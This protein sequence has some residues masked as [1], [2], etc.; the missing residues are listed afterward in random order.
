MTAAGGETFQV[1]IKVRHFNPL[2]GLATSVGVV[3][4]GE[5]DFLYFM[6]QKALVKVSALLLVFRM[7]KKLSEFLSWSCVGSKAPPN[8]DP[9]E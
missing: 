9:V 3:D 8:T 4:T 6:L 7:Q 1:W 2:M 5:M